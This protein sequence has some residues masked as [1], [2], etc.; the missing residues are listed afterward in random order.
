MA[1][2]RNERIAGSIHLKDVFMESSTYFFPKGVN[3]K[4]PSG[5]G[6]GTVNVKRFAGG[7][8]AA[9]F[10][11]HNQAKVVISSKVYPFL[12]SCWTD[13]IFLR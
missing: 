2:E 4:Q 9:Y 1:M 3:P 7:L 5:S 11:S 12:S 6:L 13:T 10:S 8:Y